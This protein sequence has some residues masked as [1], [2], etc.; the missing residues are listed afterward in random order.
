MYYL[1]DGCDFCGSEHIVDV[2][3]YDESVSCVCKKCY[4]DGCEE[5]C[6][7]SEEPFDWQEV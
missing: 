5:F 1:E 2:S 4:S 6:K 3:V 7:I